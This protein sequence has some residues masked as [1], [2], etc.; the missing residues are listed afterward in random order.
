[1]TWQA[2]LDDSDVLALLL[3][4]F[5][6]LLFVKDAQ[7]RIVAANERFLSLYPPEQ[8]PHVIGTTTVESYPKEQ[9]EVFLAEDAKALT[10]GASEVVETVDFPNGECRTFLTRKMGQTGLDGKR[11]LIATSAD[12]TELEQSRS[13]ASQL[14][15]LLHHSAA[16]IY[17]LDATTLAAIRLSAGALK[18]LGI[19]SGQEAGI[20]FET[21]LDEPTRA[22]FQ[23]VL[24]ALHADA[25]AT[26]ELSGQ[27]RRVDGSRYEVNSQV[28]TGKL[29]A[30]DVIMIIARDV[31]RFTQQQRKLE[32]QNEALN[33]FAY[34]V[35][36]DLRSPVVSSIALLDIVQLMLSEGNTEQALDVLARAKRALGQAESL[37]SDLLHLTRLEN[38]VSTASEVDL[39]ALIQ[40]CIERV[41][42]VY[43][44]GLIDIRVDLGEID[45]I[46]TEEK[47]MAWVIENM[48][49]NA[50]KYRDPE[51]EQSWVEMKVRRNDGILELSFTDNGLGIDATRRSKVFQMFQRFH[52]RAAMGAGLGLYMVRLTAN[53][54]GG[55]ATYEP[56]STGSRFTITVS[57]RTQSWN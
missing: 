28:L 7:S 8:R 10:E 51:A 39:T 23:D 48:L 20:P 32:R 4:H 9:R 16:E 53:R 22:L 44:E 17:I 38:Q 6:G 37:A 42:N 34:R 47:R 15:E 35:S 40:E 2:P 31:T 3:E 56:T 14:W 49:S 52:A 55:N 13:E 11:Y 21:W 24:S 54:L 25:N 1:M 29:A 33:E 41:H 18:N 46:V 50:T 30:G 45:T 5:P 19:E 26:Q 27:H 57:E 43:G 36:H 12:I